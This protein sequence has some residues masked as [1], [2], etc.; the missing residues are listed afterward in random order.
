MEGYLFASLAVNVL[1]AGLYLTE[2]YWLHR[3][4]EQVERCL[5]EWAES[6]ALMFQ[7]WRESDA[8]LEK[9]FEREQ[10]LEKLLTT[11]E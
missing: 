5:K 9:R 8:L 2:R 11:K 6:D 4:I 7:K 10:A 3:A 1:L